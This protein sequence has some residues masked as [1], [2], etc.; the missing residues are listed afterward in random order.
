MFKLISS[1]KAFDEG[2][3]LWIV[4][5]DPENFWFLRINSKLGFIFQNSSFEKEV[6]EP[7]LTGSRNTFPNK[8]ILCLPYKKD[9]IK[10]C[11]KN[12]SDL[13]K[14]SLR[15]FLPQ[16]IKPFE[17]DNW[18]DTNKFHSLSYLKTKKVLLER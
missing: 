1:Y 16:H 10:S 17:L 4:D 6:Q 13:K 9:W 11:Y 7:I 15:L 8:N 2:S 18:P 14:P 5:P 12:W 3:D